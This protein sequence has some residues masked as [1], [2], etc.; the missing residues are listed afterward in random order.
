MPWHA[1]PD[2]Q[3][4]FAAPDFSYIDRK[5]VD[6]A[7]EALAYHNF[8][9]RR[10]VQENGELEP[11][12]PMDKMR[13]IYLRDLSLLGECDLVFSL[14][15]ERDPG[16]LVEIG[17][18]LAVNKPVITYDPHKENANTMVAAGSTVYSDK[19]DTCLNGLFEVISRLRIARI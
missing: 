19:L 10:P 5:Y 15:L 11:H 12:S 3:I 16:T 7:L 4:Y 8:R 6:G 14:P 2:F 13:A 1:R 17:L 18:A 9:P